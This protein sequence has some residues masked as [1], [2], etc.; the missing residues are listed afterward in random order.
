MN[1]KTRQE[2]WEL[3]LKYGVVSGSMPEGQWDLTDVDLSGASLDGANLTNTNFTNA[4]LSGAD[5]SGADLSYVNFHRTNLSYTNLSNTD[6]TGANLTDANLACAVLTRAVL[7]NA[8]FAG[9]NIDFASWPLWCGSLRAKLDSEQQAQL[10]YHV[11]SVLSAENL[12]LAPQVLVDFANG[13]RR[14]SEGM[15]REIKKGE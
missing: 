7:T 15:C 11:L 14:V 5:L 8:N 6:L 1:R 3:L 13:F 9:A 12:A 4:T 2:T 10:L